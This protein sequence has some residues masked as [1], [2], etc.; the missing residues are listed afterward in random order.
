MLYLVDEGGIIKKIDMTA[1]VT[2][3]DARES[4]ASERSALRDISELEHLCQ[5]VSEH[6]SVIENLRGELQTATETIS[7]LQIASANAERLTGEVVSLKASVQAEKLKAKR[8]WRLRCEQMLREEDR[9]QAKETEIA[10]LREQLNLHETSPR[11][12]SNAR[13]LGT[14]PT[15]STTGGHECE[16]TIHPTPSVRRGKAPP[17]EAFTGD[18]ATVHWDD[19]LPTLERE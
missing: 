7:E 16:M 14:S 19:W 4:G 6:E 2:N 3:T 8:F 1:H 10:E 15:R 13:A 5:L 11:S 9:L 18:E 17:V 12:T